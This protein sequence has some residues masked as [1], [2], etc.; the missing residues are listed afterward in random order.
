MT[1]SIDINCFVGFWPF[2]RISYRSV[3]DIRDLMDRTNTHGVLLTPLASLFYKDT[4]SAVSELLEELNVSGHKYMWPIAVINPRFPGW[5]DDMSI[6]LDE[7]GCVAVRL[8]P[9]YHAYTL[10]DTQIAD[11][12]VEVQNRDLPL[13]VSVRMEDERLHHWM[14]RVEPVSHLDI[15][16]L[17][18]SYPDIKTI[19]CGLHPTELDLITDDLL[20]HSNAYVDTSIRMPQFY[21]EEM[22]SRLGPERIVYGTAMPLNY[23]ES[24]LFQLNNAHISEDARQCILCDN[25]SRLFGLNV[26][27]GQG[28][29]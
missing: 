1:L 17:L 6:M 28:E 8:F 26:Q 7:W 12:F 3:N 9:N 25:A 19:L 4:L 22:I 5:Q 11:F 29:K 16:W 24:F 23:P 18:R 10:P 27:T 14:M 21:M 2:R 20:T 15:T 13:I